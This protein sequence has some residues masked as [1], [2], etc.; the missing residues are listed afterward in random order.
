MSAA[1]FVAFVAALRTR[2]A[3][4]AGAA[5]IVLVSGTG[6]TCLIGGREYFSRVT[7][8]EGLIEAC[9]EVHRRTQSG[10]RVLLFR[11]PITVEKHGQYQFRNI[12]M[13]QH[14]YYMDRP[15]DVERDPTRV[16]QRASDYSLYVAPHNH[17]DYPTAKAVIQALRDR[18]PHEQVG[19]EMMFV[20]NA[21]KPL[22]SARATTEKDGI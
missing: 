17:P 21:D 12:T 19:T 5:T 13:P 3:R 11:R 10:D 22:T 16:I 4:V 14:A 15:F 18:F 2:S 6:T 8:S 9:R 20:L 1:A 7:F